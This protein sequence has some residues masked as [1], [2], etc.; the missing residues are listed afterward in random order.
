MN[1]RLLVLALGTFAI[2]TG[3][4]VFVG[5]L[6]DVAEDLSVSVGNAGQ[7][8]TLYAIV[9]AVGSP[10]LVTLTGAVA[11]RRLLIV[12]LAV[13]AGSRSGRRCPRHSLRLARLVGMGG[14]ALCGGRPRSVAIRRAP[15]L[16]C[17]RKYPKSIRTDHPTCATRAR[18]L[19]RPRPGPSLGPPRPPGSWRPSYAPRPPALSPRRTRRRTRRGCS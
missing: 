7:L 2:G 6:G 17:L 14:C 5:L 18:Y 10:V 4:F 16:A 3:S 9:Y 1:L 15:A 11:R 12:S 19:P 8:I 13:F